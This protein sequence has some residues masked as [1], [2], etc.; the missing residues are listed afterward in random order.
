MRHV[1]VPRRRRAAVGE[2]APGERPPTRLR[3]RVSVWAG[4]GV[5]SQVL[6]LERKKSKEVASPSMHLS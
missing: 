4:S 2:G 5:A 3:A 6:S 1:R